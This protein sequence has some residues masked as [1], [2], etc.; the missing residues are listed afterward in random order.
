MFETFSEYWIQLGAIGFLVLLL[1]WV[2]RYLFTRSMKQSDEL[3]KRVEMLHEKLENTLIENSKDHHEL[4]NKNT[5]AFLRLIDFLENRF[6]NYMENR[7]KSQAELNQKLAR[8][9]EKLD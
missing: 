8:L 6:G 4:I 7:K 2:G 9:I 1:S 3:M 5:E